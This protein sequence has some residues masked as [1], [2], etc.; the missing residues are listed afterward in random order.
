MAAEVAVACW[1][2][3]YVVVLWLLLFCLLCCSVCCWLVMMMVTVAVVGVETYMSFFCWSAH[4]V[5]FFGERTRSRE[6]I[7]KV[8]LFLCFFVVFFGDPCL[9]SRNLWR[10][11]A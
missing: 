6:K 4:E 2:P 11:L 3:G 5:G 8:V 9:S 1:M 10:Y 7:R